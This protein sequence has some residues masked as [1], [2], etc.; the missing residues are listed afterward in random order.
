MQ[1][2]TVTTCELSL[3]IKQVDNNI[4]FSSIIRQVKGSG[5]NKQSAI[6]NAISKIPTSDKDFQTFI[7]TGKGKIIQYYES[8]CQDIIS[9]SESLVKMQKYEDALGLLL[10]V[11]EV[12][13]CYSKVQGKSFEVFKAF[14]NQ[15]CATK[16]QEAKTALATNNYNLALE[17]LGQIDPSTICFKESQQL[18]KSAESKIDAEEKKQWDLQMK[19]YNDA[20]SLEKQRINAIKDVASAYYKSKPT[21]VNYTTIIK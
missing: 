17:T 14:Q 5:N 16:L 20:V 18:M 15:K 2:I 11:P 19:I 10:T 8:K 13:S 4:L 6:T 1:N 3:Y 12:V 9:K 21:S 7:E